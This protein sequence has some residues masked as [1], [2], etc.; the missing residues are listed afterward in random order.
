MLRDMNLPNDLVSLV[1]HLGGGEVVGGQVGVLARGPLNAGELLLGAGHEHHEAHASGHVS[2]GHGD[3]LSRP[4]GAANREQTKAENEG[5][6]D[7]EDQE[8]GQV[9][10]EDLRGGGG[11]CLL[12]TRDGCLTLRASPE[13][14]EL[15]LLLVTS[16]R[17]SDL[18]RLGT[19]DTF[20]N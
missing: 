4:P 17:R 20:L 5:L 9:E 16:S 7:Q 11:D 15:S 14:R 10:G 18:S 12:V 3:T 2:R 1:D 19:W 8:V 6:E 13:S